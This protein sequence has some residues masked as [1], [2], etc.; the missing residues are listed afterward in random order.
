[1]QEIWVKRE[2][3][4]VGDVIAD[5][6][7]HDYLYT[8]IGLSNA[9]GMVNSISAHGFVVKGRECWGDRTY[10]EFLVKRKPEVESAKS[11]WARL[12]GKEQPK[13][14]GLVEQLQAAD[15]QPSKRYWVIKFD[16]LTRDECFERYCANMREDAKH[17]LTPTQ[18][19]VAQDMWSVALRAKQEQ[20]R[21]LD[22]ER[23][24]SV[25]VEADLDD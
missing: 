15:P 24:V 19:V 5:A 17:L 1:M 13:P 16:G 18:N 25:R 21:A 2:D 23:T 14:G 6:R 4:R 20:Q 9:L 10:T 8:T 22:A 11:V 7:T 3:V 12:E